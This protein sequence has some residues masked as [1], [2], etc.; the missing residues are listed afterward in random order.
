MECWRE[1]RGLPRCREEGCQV[2]TQT[3]PAVKPAETATVREA[4][5]ADLWAVWR[6]MRDAFPDDRPKLAEWLRELS[7]PG[8]WLYVEDAGASLVRGYVMIRGDHA[9]GYLVRQIAVD[10]SYRRQGVG[11]SLLAVVPTPAAAWIREANSAS[12]A[13]FEGAGFRLSAHPASSEPPGDWLLYS[14]RSHL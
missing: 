1:N 14:C 7:W 5:P 2:P 13:L 8:T 10:P 4:L 3:P 9:R 11:R 6:L 12:R